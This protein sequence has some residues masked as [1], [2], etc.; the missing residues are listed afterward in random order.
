MSAANARRNPVVLNTGLT[1]PAVAAHTGLTAGWHR[2]AMRFGMITLLLLAAPLAAA[3]L[4]LEI[5]PRWDGKKMTV[6]AG[7]VVTTSG[8]TVSVTRLAALL[9]EVMLIRSD[10]G[11]VRLD[12]QYGFIDAESGRIAVTLRSVPEGDYAGLEFSLGVPAEVNHGDPG[13]WPA[14]HALNPLVNGLHWGWQGGYVFLALEG[15]W[16][17]GESE[18]GEGERG[19][20]C[21]LAT[22][23]RRMAVRFAAHYR[24]EGATTIAL[25]LDLAKVL[26]GVRLAADDGSESTHSAVGDALAEQ[27]ATATERAW[28]WL[29]A[30]ATEGS[31]ERERV[32]RATEPLTHARRYEAHATP[33]A[34]SVPAGFPQPSLPADN[35]LTVEG[36]TLGEKLFFDVRLSGNGAQSCAS[37]HAPS[38]AFSDVVALSR[39]ADGGHGARNAMPLGNLAWSPSYGWDGSKPRI[40]DQ[41]LAAMTNPIEM[42]G[43]PARVAAALAGDAEM[44]RMF[45][46]AFGSR[47]ITA[48]RIGLALEQYLLTLVSADSKFDRTLRGE[49]QMTEEE[50]Q[51]FK[52]FVTEY[53]P[54]RGKRGADC[55]HCHG[56]ALFSDFAFKNNGLDLVSADRGRAGVTGRESDAAKFKTPS[57]RNVAVTAPYMHDGRFATLEDVIAHYDHGVKRAAALDPNLAKHPAAGLGL[58]TEEQGALVAFLRTL[59]ELRELAPNPAQR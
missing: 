50:S 36:V 37:C 55:F 14:G 41:A 27:L 12:G 3:E 6:P 56:G 23:E 13:K 4:T 54:A 9:S 32:N 15:K 18:N 43:E 16:R 40:R 38:R 31:R 26:R 45:S 8:Q 48:E 5:E 34:F 53:D 21:H 35:A 47:E 58:T 10:G 51:G 44:A 29:E 46:A 20:S 30:K 39:G 1:F 24:V 42:H 33:L 49:A 57:L 59:T 28:F 19:F 52:L 25:A 11:A 22:D 7:A 17:S 2:A